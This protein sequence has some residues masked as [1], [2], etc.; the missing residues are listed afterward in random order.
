MGLAHFTI[1]KMS[2]VVQYQVGSRKE[3]E[4]VQVCGE[5]IGQY[6]LVRTFPMKL[7]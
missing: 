4:V 5:R 6:H 1:D 2:T 3:K 7:K